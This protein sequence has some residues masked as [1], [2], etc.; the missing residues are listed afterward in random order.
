MP[1]GKTYKERLEGSQC[2]HEGLQ[3]RHWEKACICHKL[4]LHAGS[5]PESFNY[6]SPW[7][8]S[9]WRSWGI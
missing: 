6:Y 9:L 1:K 8:T 2:L 5:F 7:H 4:A 3:G